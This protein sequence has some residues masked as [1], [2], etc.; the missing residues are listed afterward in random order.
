MTNNRL[1]TKLIGTDRAVSA[2]G[3]ALFRISF[4]CF[5]AIFI[6]NV[7]YFKPLVFNSFITIGPNP[8]PARL[9]LAIWFSASLSILIGWQTRIAA[10]INYLCVVL[11]AYIFSNNGCG[12]F[13]DDLL[14]IGSFILIIFPTHKNYSIDAILHT[15]KYGQNYPNSTSRYNYL[16]AVFIS[17]GLMY[18]ASSITKLVSPIW[19]KGLGLWTP[20]VVPQ[21]KWNDIDLL[22]NQEWLMIG[23][24]YLTIIWEFLFIAA[25]FNR[26]LRP[27][28]A[29]VGIFFHLSIAAIFPFWLL[30]FGPLPFYFLLFYDK[31]G[32]KSTLKAQL[33]I[34]YNSNSSR[35]TL[36][37][38]FV[39][40]LNT[41]IK[42]NPIAVGRLHVNN[43]H[44]NSNWDAALHLL[45]K[46]WYGPLLSW[47]FKIKFGQLLY[48]FIADDVLK[49]N[50]TTSTQEFLA[51]K[52]KQTALIYFSVLL[53][54]VQV[55][56][57][58]YHLV[59]NKEEEI[60]G[61]DLTE[62]K[63]RPRKN[64]SDASLK[65]ANLFRTLLGIN[66]RGVF[67]D[68]SSIGNKPV[69]A[70]TYQTADGQEHWLP[71][72]TPE[73]YCLSYNMNQMWS[74]YS[75]N[76]VCSGTIPNPIGLQ[77]VIAFWAQKNQQSLDSMDFTVLKR[78]YTFPT[79]F[80]KNYLNEQKKLPWTPE[81][82]VKW[83]KGKFCYM[84]FDSLQNTQN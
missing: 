62:K 26:S 72:F 43:N 71:H 63:Y 30:C 20:A 15:I 45:D 42:L 7:Y 53:L 39:Q 21:N 83:R 58:T 73:G 19:Q 6:G 2:N 54:F 55:F 13:N 37:V 25:V 81:G 22:L 10:W 69:F 31:I 77:Q 9:F 70:I 46:H 41:N 14:R 3:F 68:H 40:A 75:F 27:Y 24:N 4:A 8:F 5:M 57:S 36:F 51:P 79:K 66:A 50:Q 1:F 28:F 23:V 76:S 78:V 32:S 61:I 29:W 64:I 74:Q 33:C 52:F 34:S 67:L 16:V 60:K 18:W 59:K 11:A 56:Y 84:P 80:K 65:P 82:I 44:F 48:I 17:L 12:A 35:Q 38:R 49:I 47:T